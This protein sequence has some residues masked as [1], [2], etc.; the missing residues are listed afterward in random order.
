MRRREFLKSATA[1]AGASVLANHG[2]SHAQGLPGRTDGWAVLPDASE[3][4]PGGSPVGRVLEIYLY[5]GLSPWETF[6]V[7]RA[8]ARA[9]TCSGSACPSGTVATTDLQ[10][11]TFQCAFESIYRNVRGSSG[12]V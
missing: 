1:I 6:Y 2:S 11:G 12:P 5:G 10:W 4:W 8:T 7:N 3:I 9:G